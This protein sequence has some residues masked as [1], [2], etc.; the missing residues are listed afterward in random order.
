[1]AK[2]LRFVCRNTL[3][4]RKPLRLRRLKHAAS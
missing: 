4:C 1:L 3:F 2:D